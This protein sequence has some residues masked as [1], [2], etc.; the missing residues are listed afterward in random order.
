MPYTHEHSCA[1]HMAGT[2]GTCSCRARLAEA[3][4]ARARQA[5]AWSEGDLRAFGIA[6]DVGA[7][8]LLTAHMAFVPFCAPASVDG[9]TLQVPLPQG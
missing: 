4:W 1:G 7:A 5:G 9:P 2:C 6:D 3:L 8:G